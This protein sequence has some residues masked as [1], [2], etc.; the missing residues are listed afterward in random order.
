MQIWGTNKWSYHVNPHPDTLAVIN[1]ILRILVM[2]VSVGAPCCFCT[3]INS[4]KP[5]I[6]LFYYSSCSQ[7]QKQKPDYYVVTPLH[8]HSLMLTCVPVFCFLFVFCDHSPC[9]YLQWSPHSPNVTQVN[10]KHC[11]KEE[12]GGEETCRRG[13][14]NCNESVRALCNA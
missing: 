5:L 12:G 4:T 9:S 2:H 11:T 6:L 10:T 1:L 3:T 13:N 8:C 14:I 7:L